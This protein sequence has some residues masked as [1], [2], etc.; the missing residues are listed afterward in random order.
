MAGLREMRQ[1][2]PPEQDRDVR[3]R[4]GA[5]RGLRREGEY[6]RDGAGMIAIASAKLPQGVKGRENWGGGCGDKGIMD[7][8]FYCST[9][10][11]NVQVGFSPLASFSFSNMMKSCTRFIIFSTFLWSFSFIK[12]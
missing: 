11:L 5:V 1:G 2:V 4:G 3:E 9:L 8:I 12:L 7:L 6:A 10:P